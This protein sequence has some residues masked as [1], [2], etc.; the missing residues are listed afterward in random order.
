MLNVVESS[1]KFL[2]THGCCLKDLEA[3]DGYRMMLN[4]TESS[5]KFL[6]VTEK[7]WRQLKV[8]E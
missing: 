5:R 8:R 4:M 1:R 7:T 2:V 6:V 3:T